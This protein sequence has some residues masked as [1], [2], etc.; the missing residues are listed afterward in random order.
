MWN[1]LRRHLSVKLFL[2]YLVVILI[3]I[4]IQAIAV[5]MVI[6]DAFQRHMAGMPGTPGQGMGAMMGAQNRLSLLSSFRSGVNE[7]LAVAAVA[8][9]LAAVAVSVWMSRRVVAPVQTLTQ[10]SRRIADGH[11]DQRVGKLG[12]T[13]EAADELGQL[14]HAF[15]QMA[16]RLEHTE[17]MRSQLIGDV[18]HELRTPLTVIKGTM[19]ALQDGVL[20]ATPATFMQV[21][22]EAERLQR[23]V[24]DLQELSRVEAGAYTLECYPLS[25]ETLVQTAV[26]R[27]E[28]TFQAKQIVVT[29]QVAPDLPVVQGDQD[30]LLQVLLNLLSNAGQYTLAGGQ[31]RVQVERRG[32]EVVLAVKDTGI[33]IAPEHIGQLFTRFYRV[34]KSR[35]RQAGGGSG[36][37]LTIAKHLVEAH[38]GRLWAESP[39]TGQGSTFAFALPIHTH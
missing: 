14:A 3:G 12:G 30:R 39:G 24:N 1:K 35:S 7:A 15:D 19:E 22:Q 37:G 13:P 32:G 6:P 34:D 8:A 38:G 4:L 36:I 9:L 18:S 33:G 25:V 21:E 31:V 11:Y 28:Q 5:E 17:Q 29:A 23:L 16:E 20:P 10:A 27:L 26:R 2:S